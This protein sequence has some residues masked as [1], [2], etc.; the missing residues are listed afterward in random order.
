M[1]LLTFVVLLAG[2]N[3]PHEEIVLRQIRDVVV[4]ANSEPMLRANAIFFN[5]NKVRGKLKRINVDIYINGKKSAR[6]DQKLR[7]EIP[8]QKEFSVPLEVKLAIKELG[9]MDTLLGMIGGKKLEVRYQGYLKLTYHG[10]PIRVPVDYT[11]NI[12]IS[13]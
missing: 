1:L 10:F 8:A 4:D 13:F 2:C 3:R 7:T 12:R 11:D 6:V 5:P 9:F